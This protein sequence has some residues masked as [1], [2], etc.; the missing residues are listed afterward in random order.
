MKK[1]ILLALVCLMF[2]ACSNDFLYPEAQEIS[3]AGDTIYVSKNET[4]YDV[5]LSIDV[6][7]INNK[8][9]KIK[10]FPT[11]LI[12][13]DKEGKVEN[14]K[15]AL[16]I[17]TNEALEYLMQNN[18]RG[19][20]LIVE[21]EGVGLYSFPVIYGKEGAI[22]GALTFYSD[23]IVFDSG[24]I[25]E[26]GFKNE[27]LQA[28]DWQIVE[29]PSWLSVSK[30]QG[31]VEINGAE[32][33]TFTLGKGVNTFGLTTGRVV[34]ETINPNKQYVFNVTYNVSV[35]TYPGHIDEIEGMVV[36]ADFDIESNR[37]FLLTQKPNRLL[38][39]NATDGVFSSI[40]LDKVPTCM[41]FLPGYHLALIGYTVSIVSKVDIE[42]KLIEKDFLLDA[43]PFDIAVGAGDLCYIS[44]AVDQW[45]DLTYLN[46]K[47]GEISK[48]KMWVQLYESS[49][50]TYLNVVGKIVAASIRFTTGPY[51]FDVTQDTVVAQNIYLH[52]EIDNRLW[53][54]RDS[55]FAFCRN[56]KIFKSDFTDIDNLSF[57]EFGKID[58]ENPFLTWM[59]ESFDGNKVYVS[60]FSPWIENEKS[61]YVSIFDMKSYSEVDKI[62]PSNLVSSRAEILGLNVSYVFVT[63]DGVKLYM[64]NRLQ[65]RHGD[66]KWYLERRDLE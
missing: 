58:T 53:F 60:S 6:D 45:V 54:T 42:G 22:T 38:I 31:Q 24:N 55:H 16:A 39:L 1:Y 46:F 12:F 61:S 7:G 34:I 59:H 36:D 26:L 25:K 28:T 29:M 21:V 56:T 30:H 65:E 13:P 57:T 49:Y 64:V 50:L 20:V 62:Y 27:S 15:I 63:K 51:V 41:A 2:S 8:M 10:R 23:S 9:F 37:L 11:E 32:M 35:Q 14:G 48:N 47:S 52:K 40:D 33:L 44:P 18:K 66:E 43:V 5:E 17:Y 4:R 19:G 3:P